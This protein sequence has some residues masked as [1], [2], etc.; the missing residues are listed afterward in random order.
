MELIKYTTVAIIIKQHRNLLS[1][2]NFFQKF[3]S[4]G[5]WNKNVGWKKSKN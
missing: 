2:L 1:W 3:N 5:G 4:R